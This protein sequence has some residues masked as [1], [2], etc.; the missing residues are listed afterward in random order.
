MPDA[1]QVPSHRLRIFL[2]DSASLT[3]R[4]LEE[5][6]INAP[7]LEA[8]ALARK[9]LEGAHYRIRGISWGP[10]DHPAKPPVLI[11]Y[12]MKEPTR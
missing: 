3:T 11:A 12:V 5:A 1:T 4:E 6:R 2:V 10:D 8:R 7:K 9:Q